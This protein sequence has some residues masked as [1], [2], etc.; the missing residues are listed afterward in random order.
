MERVKV[1]PWM[2]EDLAKDRPT[3][4]AWDG[5]GS[6]AA[7]ADAWCGLRRAEG[8]RW[9]T[10]T[11]ARSAR[12]GAWSDS[13]PIWYLTHSAQTF[14]VGNTL[15]EASGPNWT[16]TVCA[17]IDS[18]HLYLKLLTGAIGLGE[19]FGNGGVSATVSARLQKT[20]TGSAAWDDTIGDVL[21][22]ALAHGMGCWVGVENFECGCQVWPPASGM[23][24]AHAW[25][26]T[27]NDLGAV[28]WEGPQHQDEL[29]CD[30]LKAWG[31]VFAGF[32][33]SECWRWYQRHA[34]FCEGLAT[35]VNRPFILPTT[36]GA[37]AWWFET[38]FAEVGP[39]TGLRHCVSAVETYGLATDAAFYARIDALR[40]GPLWDAGQAITMQAHAGAGQLTYDRLAYVH[41]AGFRGPIL[42]FDI[43]GTAFPIS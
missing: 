36:V 30:E 21:G 7:W 40:G 24:L 9:F 27:T 5:L 13:T 6:L 20:I 19:T 35:Y 17:V 38:E 10:H 23:H 39:V 42:L 11:G 3:A 15:T 29:Y 2:R 18:T 37:Y 34:D 31:D 43:D 32:V 12:Y 4:N 8:F 1:I 41:Q 33:S 26:G 14:A 16:G 25:N 22:A 28:Q